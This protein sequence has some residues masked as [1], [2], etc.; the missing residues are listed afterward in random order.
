MTRSVSCRTKSARPVRSLRLSL[1]CASP[2]SSSCWA[3]LK[4]RLYEKNESLSVVHA[5]LLRLVEEPI[6]T[7]PDERREHE[8]RECTDHAPENPVP[9]HFGAGLRATASDR[10]RRSLRAGHGVDAYLWVESLYTCQGPWVLLGLHE[11][12]IEERGHYAGPVALARV[13]KHVL[14]PAI[15]MGLVGVDLFAEK[16]ADDLDLSGTART[17][18]RLAAGLEPPGRSAPVAAYQIVLMDPSDR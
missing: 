12:R 7:V 11:G 14:V 10:S 16:V 15:A 17:R 18:K 1:P 13:V 8:D 9:G 2:A 5:T 6:A 3:G 4:S